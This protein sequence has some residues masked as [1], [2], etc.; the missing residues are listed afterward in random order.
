M[1]RFLNDDFM[2][3]VLAFGIFS[4]RPIMAILASGILILGHLRLF[5]RLAFRFQ[6]DHDHL[7][8]PR[9]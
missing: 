8:A 2:M 3:I 4:S 6:A 5:E 1:L 9:L 7:G